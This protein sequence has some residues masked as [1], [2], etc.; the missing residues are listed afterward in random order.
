[1][2]T[3]SH[4]PYKVNAKA[5]T[6]HDLLAE[7]KYE[8]DDFQREYEWQKK[9]VA[10]L[11][12]DLASEFLES[13]EEGNERGEVAKYGHYFLGSIIIN[14]DGER[15]RIIDG[16]QRLTTLILLLI[17]LRHRT[18]DAE[19]KG[20]IA[21]LIRSR[22]FGEIS[23]NLNVPEREHCMQTLYNGE[24]FPD[25]GASDSVSNIL[26]R[27]D[28]IEEHLPKT[29]PDEALPY[30]ADWLVENVQLVEITTYSSSD[31]YTIFE[32]TN[33]RGLSLAPADM[34]KG[35]LLANIDEAKRANA[36]RIWKERSLSLA[37]IGKDEDADCIKS[38]LRGQH[39]T[40]IRDRKIGAAPRDY[41]RIG[42]EFHIWV[43]EHHDALGLISS[44]EFVRIIERDFAFYSLWYESLRRASEERKSELKCVHYN[45]QHNFT[46]QYPVLLASLTVND[47]R[48]SARCKLR[49]V[50]AWLDIL[51]Y[52]RIWNGRTISCTSMRHDMFARM[53]DIR[54]KDAPTLAEML[55]RQLDD[56]RETFAFRDKNARFALNAANGPQIHRLLARMTDY[57][58]TSSGQASRYAEYSQRG[59]HGYEIEHIWA[60]HPECHADEYDLTQP[61]HIGDSRR[62]REKGKEPTFAFS[63]HRNHIGGLLLLPKSSN[64]SYGD[65]PY[66]EKREHYLKQNLLA[67]SLH[68]KA[69]ERNPGFLRFIEESGLPFRAHVEFKRKDLDARQDLYQKLAERIWDPDRL[70]REATS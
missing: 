13:H 15:K 62:R 67:S 5:R 59:R 18:D 26:E 46:L 32:T 38:W 17:L 58:E 33:D 60:N 43:R 14:E 57:V 56:A 11:I 6:I 55:R 51:I 22:K 10:K 2:T 40:T 31:A 25:L 66:A 20:Q 42:T 12:D 53:R 54:G 68:E 37:E 35:H 41:E 48:D 34:L 50:S 19:Q 63:G 61:P 3:P 49:V 69:Y 44:M 47:D 1:M 21:D 70:M 28:D 45:A 64:A 29:V 8:I 7:H 65:L 36:N 4:R 24:K 30:F 39:A 9:Q 27:Y 23:F 16:Q 52:R